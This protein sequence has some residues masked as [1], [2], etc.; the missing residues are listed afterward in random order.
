MALQ[1]LEEH[2]RTRLRDRNIYVWLRRVCEVTVVLISCP[3]PLNRNA[4]A[5]FQDDK[6]V[7]CAQH[8]LRVVED[9]RI[10]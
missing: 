6:K 9:V 1:V 2:Q 3:L 10:V 7:Y 4:K 8:S 5:I